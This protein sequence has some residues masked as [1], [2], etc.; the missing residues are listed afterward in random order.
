[1]ARYTFI[2]EQLEDSNLSSRQTVEFYAEDL[3]MMLQQFELFLRGSGF[4]FDGIIDIVSAE[5]LKI[6][7]MSIHDELD[8]DFDPKQM[9]LFDDDSS[10]CEICGLSKETMFVH[11]C[12]D[13]KCPKDTW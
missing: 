9:S 6:E 11:N 10:F 1:M 3:S 2:C 8:Y 4:Y 5:R 12:Y 13:K 7:D